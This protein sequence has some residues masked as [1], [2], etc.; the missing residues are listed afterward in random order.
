MPISDVH[1]QDRAQRLIQRA[2]FA[3]RLPH[4]YIFHGPDG[5]GKELFAERLAAIMLCEDRRPLDAAESDAP[6][7]ACG[8]CRSCKLAAAGNHPDLHVVHRH[9]NVHHPDSEVRKRKAIDLGVDVIRHFVIDPCGVKPAMGRAKVFIVR[10]ADGVSP[11]AQNALLKTLE[12]PPPTTHLILLAAS[13]DRFLPTTRSRCQLIGFGSLPRDYIA[14]RLAEIRSDLADSDTAL[15]AA[16]ADGSLGAAVQFAEQNIRAVN[17]QAV[18]L[19]LDLTRRSALDAAAAFVEMAKGLSKWY[20][21]RDVALTD[22]AAQRQGLSLVL[23][24]A[25]NAY[26]DALHLA[27]GATDALVNGWARDRL[28]VMAESIGAESLAE[29]IPAIAHAEWTLGRNVN[30][31][32]AVESLMFNLVNAAGGQSVSPQL[33]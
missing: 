23:G 4:A 30:T 9:L 18:N 17:E 12:E 32:L 1:H 2:L 21:E 33:V 15:Y 29:M 16:L 3:Q 20:C 5:V 24:L 13:A 7:D 31:Q 22:T 28:A 11:G 19:Q 14:R 6:I 25:A 8:A 10:E 26:R 27:C